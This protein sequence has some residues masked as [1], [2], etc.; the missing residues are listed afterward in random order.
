MKTYTLLKGLI[1]GVDIENGTFDL[2]IISYRDTVDSKEI[3]H[4]LNC[5]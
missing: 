4:S 5:Q 3:C 2:R 1:E